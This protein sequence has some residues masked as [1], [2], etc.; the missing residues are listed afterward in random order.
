MKKFTNLDEELIKENSKA[1]QK[2]QT[3]IDSAFM[4]LEMIVNNLEEMRTEQLKKSGNWSYVGDLGH[5][6]SELDNMLEFL[7]IKEILDNSE[8][9]NV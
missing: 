9:F 4:K 7:G 3:L 2:F 5:I 8:K 1:N 6:N